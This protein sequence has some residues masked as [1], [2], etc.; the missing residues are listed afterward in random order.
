MKGR[1]MAVALQRESQRIVKSGRIRGTLSVGML[2]IHAVLLAWGGQYHGPTCNEP[3]HLSAGL[4][5]LHTGRFDLYHVN[6]PLV[7]MIAAL[8]VVA[9]G[10]DMADFEWPPVTPSS[11]REWE[12]GRRFMGRSSSRA[13]WYL[14]LARGACIPF[15]LLGAVACGCWATRLYGSESG[16]FAMALWCF[17]PTVLGHGQLITPDVGAAAISVAAFYVFWSWIRK[18]TWLLAVISGVAMGLALLT[19]S[20]LIVL[21]GLWPAVWIAWRW[22]ERASLSRGKWSRQAVQLMLACCLG[23][24][25]L[26]MGYGFERTGQ[27]LGDFAF[28]SGS[29]TGHTDAMDQPQVGNRFVDTCLADLPLPFP[30]NFVQGIDAQRQEF[31]LEKWSYLR[32]EWRHGGWWYYYLYS[33]AVKVPL[34]TWLLGLLACGVMLLRRGYSA[35][36]RDEMTLLAPIVVVLVL[37]SSQTGFNHHMRYVLPILPFAFV[38]IS[39]VARAIPLRHTGIA[40]I[41]VA[42]LTWSVASSLWCY[43]HNLSYFNESIGGPRHGAEHLLSSNVDWGQDLLPLKRWLDRHPEVRPIGIAYSLPAWLVDPADLDIE[44]TVPAIGVISDGSDVPEEQLGPLPGWYAVFAGALY[45]P[46]HE[47]DYF[48]QFKPVAMVG[49][50]VYVYHISPEEA[51]RVRQEMGLPKWQISEGTTAVTDR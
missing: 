39:K 48:R 5:H 26:N 8:P 11:R 4:S 17:S 29:F 6:P 30:A 23:L 42:A 33:L 14:A 7:R 16:V 31:E 25:A 20:T 49:Y 45:Q 46:G 37:V 3:G 24:Y 47:Y 21:L 32:G 2:A 44:Y 13:C 50:S 12:A 41:S 22:P 38:W 36:W 40:V 35:T 27:R 51:Q 43:P 19:K 1:E 9:W 10:P 28:F 18:G 15:S 34:G